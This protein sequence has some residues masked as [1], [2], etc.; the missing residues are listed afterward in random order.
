MTIIYILY[1]D[2]FST[3]IYILYVDN[4]ST[5]SFNL[6]SNQSYIYYVFKNYYTFFNIHISG[7]YTSNKYIIVIIMSLNITINNN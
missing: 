4:L 1:V 5:Y 3:I 2:N 6:D 7:I